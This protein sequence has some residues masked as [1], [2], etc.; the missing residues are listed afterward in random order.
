MYPLGLC[1]FC[2]YGPKAVREAASVLSLGAERR[3]KV[4]GEGLGPPATSRLPFCVERLPN[5][6]GTGV[7]D[8]PQVVQDLG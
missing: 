1:A 4:V 5:P 2:T 3:V 6:V 8:C 7:P